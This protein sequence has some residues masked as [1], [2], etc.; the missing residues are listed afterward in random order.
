MSY[1]IDLDN[2]V[3]LT[4]VYMLVNLTEDQGVQIKHRI[5]ESIKEYDEKYNIHF[6]LMAATNE[7][8]SKLK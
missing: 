8:L 4:R 2:I 5:I 6:D 3:T 7:I 1:A